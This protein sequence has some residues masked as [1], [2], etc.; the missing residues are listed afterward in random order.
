MTIIQEIVNRV[1]YSASDNITLIYDSN[2]V[3]QIVKYA[4]NANSSP[5]KSPVITI[6]Y[7]E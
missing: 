3:N 2:E 5:A 7:E 1:G 4:F 6:K